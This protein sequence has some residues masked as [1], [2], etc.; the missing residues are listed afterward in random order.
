M[1]AGEGC[2][3][4]NADKTC[5]ETKAEAEARIKAE[6]QKRAAEERQKRK[7]EEEAAAASASASPTA[8]PTPKATPAPAAPKA[9]SP[10]E[11]V[12]VDLP[13]GFMGGKPKRV[14]IPRKNVPKGGTIIETKT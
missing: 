7:E 2:A 4:W 12:D 13:V 9:G 5:K 14:R 3:A 8:T 1:A 10:E 11:M 6:G